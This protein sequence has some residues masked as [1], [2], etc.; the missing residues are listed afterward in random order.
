MFWDV[1][2]LS[3]RSLWHSNVNPARVIVERQR[4]L[5]ILGLPPNATR[6]QIK[7][8][9]RDLAKRHHPDMGGNQQQMQR[10]VAAYEYLMKG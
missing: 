4:A 2:R 9:Y 8:R 5:S 1:L 3:A 6:Q 7:K 10:I